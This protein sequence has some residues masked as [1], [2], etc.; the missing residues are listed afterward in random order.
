MNA[1]APLPHNV[2]SVDDC[3]ANQSRVVTHANKVLESR[4][5]AGVKA[6]L[7]NKHLER[8]GPDLFVAFKGDP[9][10]WLE[11]IAR[12]LEAILDSDHDEN[13][14]WRQFPGVCVA[15]DVLRFLANA[16]EP[17]TPLPALAPTVQGGIQAQW[18]TH[19]IDLEIEYFSSGYYSVYFSDKRGEFDTL[20]ITANDNSAYDLVVALVERV[21]TRAV[22][23]RSRVAA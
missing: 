14:T 10:A 7:G 16:M 4:N 6:R 5:V 21:T 18:L 23:D 3:L 9:P 15:A 20:E 8:I 11:P 12:R 1:V 2:H 13:Q 17:Q 22:R 19:D